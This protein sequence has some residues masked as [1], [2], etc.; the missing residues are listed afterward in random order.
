[1]RFRKY[2]FRILV[3]G[4]GILNYGSGSRKPINY[5]SDQIR[6]LPEH[7]SPNEKKYV[8]KEVVPYIIK[9]D[10]VLDFFLQFH[11]IFDKW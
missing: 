10:K 5:G 9:I 11:Q 2:F 1:M 6:I 8:V 4:A 7:F 3:C